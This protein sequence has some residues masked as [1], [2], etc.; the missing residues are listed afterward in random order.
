V[1]HRLPVLVAT[2]AAA[3]AAAGAAQAFT[4]TDAI[5]PADDGVPIGTTLYLPDGAPPATGWPGL[6]MLHGLG[7]QRTDMNLLAETW[8]VPRGYAVL[9]FDARGH[10]ESGGVVEI[11]GPREIADV[12]AM[13]ELLASQP[14]VDRAHIGAWGISYGGGATW[15]ATV[16]GVPFAAINTFE[17]WTNLYSALVPNDLTKSGVVFGFLNEI[18]AS[19]VSPLV[20]GIKADL[21]ASTNLPTIRALTAERSSIQH[22][23][24]IATP[25]FMVQGRRDFAFGIDQMLQAYVKLKGPKR[26]Y[27]GNLGHPPSSFI[28]PDLPYFLAESQLWFDR[29]LKNAPNGIDTR[30]PVEVAPSPWRGKAVSYPALPPT[31]VYVASMP[32]KATI[33][34]NA[35][36]VRTIALPKVPIEQFGAPVVSVEASSTTQFPRLV[37]VLSA[38]TP[39]GEVILSDGGIQTALGPRPRTVR[40][41]LASNATLIPPR[42]RL[43]LTLASSSTAQ[44][45]RNLVYLQVPLPAGSNVTLGK[46]TV[47]L[48][49][50]KTPISR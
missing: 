5:R 2:L 41:A 45:P 38:L 24:R 36:V 3:L 11:D 6:L 35:K 33:D 16:E 21:L 10:G 28:A 43:R 26:L 27:V 25:A 48:P 19:A 14:G 23:D 34:E 32:G 18:R 15:R 29:F 13:F 30:P 17:T 42:S 40:F 12:R 1:I 46:A 49:T 39:K 7:G 4:K 22:L 50:L 31:R 44:D 9:T 37:A 47:R 8:Y 20:A